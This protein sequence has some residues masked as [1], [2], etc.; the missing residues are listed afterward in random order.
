MTY[1]FIFMLGTGFGAVTRFK[2]TN[3]FSQFQQKR[4]ATFVVNMLG[5]LIAGG[6]IPFALKNWGSIITLGFIGGF[7]TYSTFN[8]EVAN[9]FLKKQGK[10][11]LLYVFS[12]YMFGILFCLLGYLS[13]KVLI[14]NY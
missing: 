1:Y 2:V 4:L 7:T 8:N 3:I 5:C 9:L 14:L 13:I 10:L 12:S 6:L 11:S